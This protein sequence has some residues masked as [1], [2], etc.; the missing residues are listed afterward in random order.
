MEMKKQYKINE[1]FTLLEIIVSVTLIALIGT[2]VSQ[3]FLTTSR[4]GVKTEILKEVKQNGDFALTTMERMMRGAKADSTSCA[5][6]T[7]TFTNSDSG[8]T[9]FGCFFDGT[10]TRI[11]STSAVGTQYLTSQALTLG[12]TDCTSSTLTISCTPNPGI[13]VKVAV[14]FMLSQKGSSP[15]TFEQA[16]TAFE[17]SVTTRN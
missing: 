17:T 16:Q 5:N 15:S 9:T 3:A 1:G 8:V 13:P 11:A 10:V 7:V 6:N 14:K 12:G 4:S 2:V